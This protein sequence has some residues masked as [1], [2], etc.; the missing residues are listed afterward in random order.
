MR[1]LIDGYNLL[2]AMGVLHGRGG[3]TGL[4]QARRRLLGLLRGALGDAAETVTVVFDAAD[5][6]PGAAAEVKVQGIEVRFSA[7]RELADDLIERLIQHDAA[8]RQLM[9][10]S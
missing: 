5:G 6:P 10:I 4:E 1:Y 2:H 7:R 9:V 8:P 3:Q